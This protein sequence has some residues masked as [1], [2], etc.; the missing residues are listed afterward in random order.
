[1]S[2]N[3]CLLS[4]NDGY[5]YTSI[6]KHAFMPKTSFSKPSKIDNVML[7]FLLLFFVNLILE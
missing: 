2:F 7:L 1:M 5:R 6:Y 4:K 3:F